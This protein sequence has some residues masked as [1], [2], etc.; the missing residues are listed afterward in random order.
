[1][2]MP[3]QIIDQLQPPAASNSKSGNAKPD[4]VGQKS[5]KSTLHKALGT[6]SAT[7]EQSTAVQKET[8]TTEPAKTVKM[9]EEA[10]PTA[11]VTPLVVPLV[12]VLELLPEAGRE[13]APPTSQPAVPEGF[14]TAEQPVSVAMAAPPFQEATVTLAQTT[15]NS[16]KGEATGVNAAQT[17]TATAGI[18]LAAEA[19]EQSP[20]IPPTET[21]PLINKPAAN[22]AASQATPYVA[23]NTPNA[24]LATETV[25]TANLVNGTVANPSQRAQS[26]QD[27]EQT[28]GDR[29]EVVIPVAMAKE[30]LSDSADSHTADTPA[31]QTVRIPFTVTQTVKQDIPAMPLP[32]EEIPPPVKEQV[33]QA[34]VQRARLLSDGTRQQMQIQLKPEHLGTLNVQIAVENGAVTAKFLTD[35]PQVKQALEASFNQLKQDLQAQGFKVQDVAVSVAQQ[36]MSFSE[37]SR[38]SPQFELIKSKRLGKVSN[39]VMEQTATVNASLL[40]NYGGLFAGEVDYKV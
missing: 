27:S 38:R 2:E 15:G 28:A 8:E 20:V 33:V 39:E 7:G 25:N 14:I 36:G 1:M 9:T 12:A 17:L 21:T 29:M 40:E 10:P 24:G 22:Q 4:A 16:A 11:L 5:F 34:I 30:Q 23:N 18:P 19:Q 3:I 35:N 31:D 13:T 32:A 6:N 26:V 37:F